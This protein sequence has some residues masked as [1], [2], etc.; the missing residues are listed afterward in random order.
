MQDPDG[1]R[2]IMQHNIADIPDIVDYRL[3]D[4]RFLITVFDIYFGQACAVT[5]TPECG[6]FY[7]W[8]PVMFVIFLWLNMQG[9]GRSRGL[10]QVGD[11]GRS[12]EMGMRKLPEIGDSG[13]CCDP[14]S[15]GH[16][17]P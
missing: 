3:E 15:H 10:V 8:A 1:S 7:D 6:L 5:L 4:F 13:D 11:N 12:M 17:H 9:L 2:D 14:F 16:P